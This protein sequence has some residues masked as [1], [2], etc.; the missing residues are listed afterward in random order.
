MYSR[1]VLS[2]VF[3]V[4]K[5]CLYLNV[6]IY[7]YIYTYRCR[8]S[9]GSSI[10]AHLRTHA[11]HSHARAGSTRGGIVVA[12]RLSTC[13]ATAARRWLATAKKEQ[14]LQGATVHSRA[15]ATSIATAAAN[16]NGCACS[17]SCCTSAAGAAAGVECRVPEELVEDVGVAA[18]AAGHAVHAVL[19]GR[20]CHVAKLW[21]DRRHG[22]C[23]SPRRRR[24]LW[25]VLEGMAGVLLALVAPE[26]V[27]PAF[28]RCGASRE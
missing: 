27:K 10:S 28:E 14:C 20:R 18:G 1:T 26:V 5:E 2:G 8:H 24:A 13:I 19:D 23:L 4:C 9:P 21:L 16:S 15:A 7:I 11:Q 25:V 6:H 3:H 17:C 22:R 12:K